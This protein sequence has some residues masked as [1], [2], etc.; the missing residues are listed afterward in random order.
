MRIGLNLGYVLSN[1]EGMRLLA[2][3]APQRSRFAPDLPTLKEKGVDVNMASERGL[4]MPGGT[5]AHILSRYREATE[6]IAKDPE[7]IKAIEARSLLVQHEPGDAWFARLRRDEQRYRQ[8]WATT[9]WA[10]R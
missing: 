6:D 2:L 8:L 4:V 9:P 1:N 5:P 7:F 3:A 10:Q